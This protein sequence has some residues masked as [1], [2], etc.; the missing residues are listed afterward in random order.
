MDAVY[1]EDTST[2]LEKRLY[3]QLFRAQWWLEN[4]AETI[5]ELALVDS[6]PNNWGGRGTIRQALKEA[7]K[8]HPELAILPPG[9]F[10]TDGIVRGFVIERCMMSA[11][12]RGI[13]VYKVNI[14]GERHTLIPCNQA[15]RV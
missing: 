14:G 5:G 11:G 1:P 9:T 4:L 10:V 13:P 6:C 12:R 8:A 3:D 7:E 15:R 2:E